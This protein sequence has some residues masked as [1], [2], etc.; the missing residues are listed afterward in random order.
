MMISVLV[1]DGQKIYAGLV[2]LPATLG[3]DRAV[4]F[5]R[6]RPVIG[7]ALHVTSHPLEDGSGFIGAGESH[8]PRAS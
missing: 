5:Q 6:F 2:E 1:M 7:I 8:C 4:D 3:T